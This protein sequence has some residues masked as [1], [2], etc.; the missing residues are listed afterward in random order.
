M[1]LYLHEHGAIF[2]VVNQIGDKPVQAGAAV[3]VSFGPYSYI[4]TAPL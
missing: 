3:A 2:D 1:L 4:D